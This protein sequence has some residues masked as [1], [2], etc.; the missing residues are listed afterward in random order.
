MKFLPYHLQLIVQD[1]R[2][3]HRTLVLN[4][5]VLLPLSISM[6]ARSYMFYH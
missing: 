3:A 6:L 4:G 2:Y 5:L 1:V